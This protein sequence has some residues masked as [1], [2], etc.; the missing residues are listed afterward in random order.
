MQPHYQQLSFIKPLSPLDFD[1]LSEVADSEDLASILTMLLFDDT[2][3]E[4]LKQSVKAQLKLIQC[5][6]N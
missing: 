5:T 3:S 4:S 1:L 2:L 6:K